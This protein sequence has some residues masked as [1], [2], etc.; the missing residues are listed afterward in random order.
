MFLVG[1][2][3]GATAGALIGGGGRLGFFVVDGCPMSFE[4]PPCHD[5]AAR[6]AVA[7]IK[8]AREWFE[9]AFRGSHGI[10]P[11]LYGL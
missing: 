4:L 3:E 5:N 9:C 2:P 10:L 11:L 1:T 6:A 7:A 8:V